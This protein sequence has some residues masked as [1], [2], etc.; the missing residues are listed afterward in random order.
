[1]IFCWI[2]IPNKETLEK[3]G[4]Y[5]CVCE[6]FIRFMQSNPF[7]CMNS[8]IETENILKFREM[9][10][11]SNKFQHFKNN[12]ARP[13]IEQWNGQCRKKS[14]RMHLSSQ[15]TS[16]KSCY[17]REEI[18]VCLIIAQSA[19]RIL[20]EKSISNANVTHTNAT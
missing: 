13:Y 14:F 5:P 12:S 19:K 8:I 2:H 6:N 7:R 18:N 17:F 15:K 16:F 3:E 20:V 9:A 11:D 10:G 1:M 4:N